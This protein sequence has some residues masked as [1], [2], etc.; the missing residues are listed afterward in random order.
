M[1][2]NQCTSFFNLPCFLLFRCSDKIK[3]FFLLLVAPI[4]VVIILFVGFFSGLFNIS[5]FCKF[6]GTITGIYPI[7]LIVSCVRKKNKAEEMKEEALKQARAE[8]E[9]ISKHIKNEQE[10]SKH[11]KTN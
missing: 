7:I 5:C 9:K 6:L 4:F 10:T 11:F 3:K 8:L 1:C 2:E